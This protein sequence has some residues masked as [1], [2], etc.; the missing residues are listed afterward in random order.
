MGIQYIRVSC[1]SVKNVLNSI[2]DIQVNSQPLLKLLSCKN[3]DQIV[4]PTN[5]PHLEFRS[6][7]ITLYARFPGIRARYLYKSKSSE[8]AHHC[9]CRNFGEMEQF[10]LVTVYALRSKAEGKLFSV[11][12]GTVTLKITPNAQ[13]FMYYRRL[14]KPC[15]ISLDL[16]VLRRVP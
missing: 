5:V 14:M 1:G 9:S 12:R 7:I 16:S 15:P 4:S 13:C 3:S 6:N 8:R 2:L 11:C 10:C